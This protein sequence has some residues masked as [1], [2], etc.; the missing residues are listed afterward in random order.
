MH[1][2]VTSKQQLAMICGPCCRTVAALLKY[3]NEEDVDDDYDVAQ[4]RQHAMS[5]VKGPPATT[6]QQVCSIT[7]QPS[8][9]LELHHL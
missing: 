2:P 4:S 8:C 1:D 9:C 7:L 3:M 6:G 5:G